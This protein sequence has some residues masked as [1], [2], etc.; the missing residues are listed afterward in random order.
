MRPFA[1]AAPVASTSAVR[2][3]PDVVGTVQVDARAPK[4]L[5]SPGPNRCRDWSTEF[6]SRVGDY[7]TCMRKY[8]RHEH[9][10][11]GATDD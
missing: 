8:L 1:T 11:L 10:K 9:P 3:D 6:F 4:L 7:V 2:G 5:G